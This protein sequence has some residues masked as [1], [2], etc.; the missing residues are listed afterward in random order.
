MVKLPNFWLLEIKV[1][2]LLEEFENIQKM[3][4]SKIKYDKCKDK[5]IS[6]IFNNEFYIICNT[7]NIKLC[8]LWN[9]N[10]IIIII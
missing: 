10:I 7:C 6:N 9:L 4:I 1:K 8:P 5:N 3:D 2:L